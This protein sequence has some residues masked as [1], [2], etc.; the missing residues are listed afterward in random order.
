MSGSI[1]Y[2]MDNICM[3]GE[4]HELLVKTDGENVEVTYDGQ[5]TTLTAAL[6]SIFTSLNGLPTKDWVNEAI[7]NAIM[8]AI[9]ASY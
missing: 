1:K 4:L 5:V 8:G 2:I 3:D 7:E 9:N 6:T